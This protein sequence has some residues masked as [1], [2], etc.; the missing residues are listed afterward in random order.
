MFA[1]TVKIYELKT[2]LGFSAKGYGEILLRRI[3]VRHPRVIY[4]GVGKLFLLINLSEV[5]VQQKR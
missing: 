4:A 3:G 1:F 2:Y 5:N